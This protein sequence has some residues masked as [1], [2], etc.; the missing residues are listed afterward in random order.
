MLVTLINLNQDLMHVVITTKGAEKRSK[1][2][3][4]IAD[5]LPLNLRPK[6]SP[7]IKRRITKAGIKKLKY[8]IPTF[9]KSWGSYSSQNR[10]RYEKPGTR[11]KHYIS[12]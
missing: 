9:S 8:T 1:N 12:R 10:G 2:V 7:E 5:N 4:R 3:I 6:N 11:Y